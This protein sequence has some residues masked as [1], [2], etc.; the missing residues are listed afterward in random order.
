M[1]NKVWNEITL[2]A[3]VSILDETIHF[4]MG[5]TTTCYNSIEGAKT[6]IITVYFPELSGRSGMNNVLQ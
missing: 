1:L 6:R 4:K 5:L 2:N 3:W